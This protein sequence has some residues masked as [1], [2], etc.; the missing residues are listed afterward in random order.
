MKKIIVISLILIVL[1][2][3]SYL[4]IYY[5]TVNSIEYKIK[6]FETLNKG[7]L[8]NLTDMNNGVLEGLPLV[9]EFKNNSN[10]NIKFKNT[11]LQLL[12]NNGSV[13]GKIKPLKSLDIPK[14]TTVL[15]DLEIY[16]FN[17]DKM[18][19]D[20]IGV[21]IKDY[22]YKVTTKIGGFLPFSYSNKII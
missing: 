12:D 3:V 18:I 7:F 2:I 6:G 11:V 20:L 8:S 21:G 17:P 22:K 10:F 14:K 1:F 4:A 16:D 5:K 13:I 15:I 19:S 9:M